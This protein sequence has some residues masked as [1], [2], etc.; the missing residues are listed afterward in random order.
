MALPRVLTP[1]YELTLPSTGQKV[2]FRPFLVKEE[3]TLLM[4]M[5]S[6][7]GS[8]MA[9]AMRDILT[10]CTEGE[11]DL[12]SL[13]AFDIEYFFLQLRGRSV[14]ESITIHPLRPLNFKCCK[15]ATEEDI[16][17]VEINLEDIVMDTKGIKSS[18]IKITDDVGMKM[19]FPNIET[20][21][22]YANEGENI[23]AQDVFHLIVE[24]ID[25]IWDGDEIYKAKDSTKKEL[26]DFLE[27]LSSGQFT[28]VRDF[29]ES[30][31]RL[32][33]EIEWKCSK[34]KKSTNLLLQGIDAFFG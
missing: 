34:C 18:E 16:C 33:H 7:D 32:Q 4:A 27:S 9:K 28:K 29:F 23:K 14:G 6:T 10:S 31:P 30:I 2:T 17:V 20:V 11:I 15:E 13:A 22:K 19:N 21:Q 12:N 8:A 26:T 3:K 5:E 24:C 1:T 25:Y